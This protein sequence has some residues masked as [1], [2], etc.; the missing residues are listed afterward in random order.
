MKD[1]DRHWSAISKRL[2]I[3]CVLILDFDGVLSPIARIPS[4]ARIS[5]AAWRALAACAEKMPVAIISGRTLSDIEKRVGL[6][7]VIY[8]GSH[9]LEWKVNGRIH[10]KR[11]S[12]KTLSA[13]E[14]VRRS[15]LHIAKLFPGLFVEDKRNSIA[16]GYRSLSKEQVAQFR[17]GANKITSK[18]ARAGKIRVIDNL[19][20]FEVM[21]STEW[22]KG[23]C[24]K[25]I[26][27]TVAKKG[28]V[29]VYIGDTLTDE[30]A[31]HIFAKSGIT[32]R[33][34]KSFTSAAQ[35]YFK[36]RSKVDTFLVRMTHSQ[37]PPTKPPRKGRST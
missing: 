36:S 37:K 34:G 3:G 8:A 4:E 20:T 10:R 14:T 16:L 11:I 7:N 17:D 27:N 21:P 24:A 32:I 15:L 1:A 23:E 28:S 30:D 9:G 19:Y 12:L 25:H 31:F 13:F 33:V 18:V 22:T 35:F 5:H 2:R 29:A 6:R 26:F